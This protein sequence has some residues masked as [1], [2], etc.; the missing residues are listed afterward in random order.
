MARSGS[1]VSPTTPRVARRGDRG[2]RGGGLAVTVAR[3]GNGSA[4]NRNYARRLPDRGDG[5]TR[6]HGCRVPRR[7][8]CPGPAGGPEGDLAR[9][10][11]G[12]RVP[13]ALQAR[14]ADRG[15]DRPPERDRRLRGG[16]DRRPAVPVDALRRGHRSAPADP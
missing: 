14:V 16:R 1:T 11:R 12:P 2:E 10:R 3:T 9:A 7:A 5:G 8:T 4:L 13:R 15:F 6:R